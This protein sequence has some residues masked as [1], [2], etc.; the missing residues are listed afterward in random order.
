[1]L[2]VKL[3][4]ELLFFINNNIAK[5]P[6]HKFQILVGSKKNAVFEKPTDFKNKFKDRLI[7]E[8]IKKAIIKYLIFL[9]NLNNIKNRIGKKI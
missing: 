9:I 2:A 5:T 1:M 7:I 4:C 8:T 6:K 3:L